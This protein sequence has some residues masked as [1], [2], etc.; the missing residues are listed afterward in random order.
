MHFVPQLA[1]GINHSQPLFTTYGEFGS[2]LAVISMY[3]VV[4]CMTRIWS[5]SMNYRC[6]MCIEGIVYAPGVYWTSVGQKYRKYSF[7]SMGMV[8]GV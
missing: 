7:C 2:L 8:L 1:T 4:E 6:P 5:V 3:Q